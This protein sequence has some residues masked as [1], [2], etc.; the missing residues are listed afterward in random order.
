MTPENNHK[1]DS[2]T[3]QSLLLS[4]GRTIAFGLNIFVPVLLVRIFGKSEYGLYKQ[5]LLIFSTLF[6]IGELGISQSLYYFLPR[7]PDQ[8]ARIMTQTFV[9]VLGTGLLIWTGMVLFRSPIGRLMNAPELVRFL[10]LLG[11][12]TCLMIGASFLETGMIAEGKA[13]WASVVV[14][15][16]QFLNSLILVVTALIFDDLFI[17]I[18]GATLFAALR[19]CTQFVFLLKRYGISLRVLRFSMLKEQLRYSLPIGAGNAA[20]MIQGK[21]HQYFVS[22]FFN[23]AVF[24]VYA[25]GC[26]KLPL[27]DIITSSVGSVMIPAISRH[28]KDGNTQRILEIWNRAIKKMNLLLFPV[29]VFFLIT[30]DEFITILFTTEY[31]GSIPIFRIGLVL[32]LISSINTGAVL[33]AYAETRYIM[34]IAILRLPVTAVLLWVCIHLWGV[35]GAMTADALALVLFRFI[36]LKKVARVLRLPFTRVIDWRMNGRILAL[37]TWSGLPLLLIKELPIELPLFRLMVC[38]VTYPLLYGLLVFRSQ[39]LEDH[40]KSELIKRVAQVYGMLKRLVN[41]RHSTGG[42]ANK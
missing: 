32:I 23:P 3:K 33:Q 2:L 7:C 41:V 37:A 30:A 5:L 31:A 14:I 16:S 13:R 22:G 42:C 19:F 34:K 27:L 36:V 25:V 8:R 9:I 6:S 20:W 26:F 17:V 35:I 18:A 11:L 38:G 28:Q 39:C 15:L 1:Q 12:Y 29:F 4:A 21:L 10:P 24:A 40:E